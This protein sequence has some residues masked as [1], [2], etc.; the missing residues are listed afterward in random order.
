M[1]NHNKFGK[2]RIIVA[3]LFILII[4]CV[5][6]F[7]NGVPCVIKYITGISCLGCGM[8]RAWLAVFKLD[9][10]LAFYYHPLF[11]MPVLILIIILNRK[12][13]KPKA[14]SVI[15]WT[16]LI[17]FGIVYIYRMIVPGDIV[18]FQPEKGLLYKIFIN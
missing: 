10:S 2:Q 17:L 16:I 4:G 11:I 14:M 3:I 9:F 15:I 7:G 13:L 5:T 18:V 12:R 1:R 6:V 8:T